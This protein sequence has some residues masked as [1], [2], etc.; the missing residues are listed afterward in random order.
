[1]H[2]RPSR[3]LCTILLILTTISVSG[4]LDLSDLPAAEEEMK[5]LVADWETQ[6]NQDPTPASELQL[7]LSLQALGIIQRQEG[8]PTEALEHL[9]R[10]CA[11]IRPLSPESLPDPLEAKALVLQD[12]GHLRESEELLREIVSLRRN[13]VGKTGLATSLA[14]L[15]L[16]LLQQGRYPEV[17]QLLDGATAETPK[18]NPAFHATLLAHRARLLHTLGSYARSVDILTQA[19]SMD[20]ENPELRL[21]I[22]S[23]LGLSQLRLGK[24]E[25][26][27]SA[28]L[29]AAEEAKRLYL[30][31]PFLAV[32]YMNNLGAIALSLGDNETADL[33]FSEAI[34]T[35][36]ASLGT[37]H[38][39]LIVPLNNLGVSKQALGDY[40]SAATYLTRAATLQEK[41]LPPI[42]L[43]IA[44]TQRNLARNSLLSRSGD[45]AKLIAKATDTG[46]KLL[47]LLIREGTERERLNFISRFDLI[48]LP[49]A[50]G[51]APTIANVLIASKARLFDSLLSSET[52]VKTPVWQ[53]I[54]ASLPEGTVLVD[55]CRYTTISQTPESR[56]GAILISPTAPPKWIPLGSDE[57]L[58]AWLT[59]FHNRLHWCSQ[60]IQN[61]H[62]P[63]PTLKLRPILRALHSQFWAPIA[64]A[65]PPGTHTIAFSPDARIHYLPLPALLDENNTPLCKTYTQV[66][67]L[68]SARD[69]LTPP[70]KT[71]LSSSPWAIFSVSDFPSGKNPSGEKTPTTDPLLALL[72]GL[73]PIPGTKI[74]ANALKRIAPP[75]SEFFHGKKATEKAFSQLDSPGVIHIGCHAFFLGDAPTLSA[76][77]M[78]F[79]DQS[80]LLFSG[81]L[82]LY[83]GA[84]RQ[85]NAPL[86]SQTD[87]LLF[88]SEIAKLPLTHTRLVTLSSCDSGAGTPVSGEGLLGI[89]RS[90]SIAGAR[91]VLVALWPV[92]DSSTPDFMDR[93]YRLALASDRPA[94]ALWQAQAEFIPPAS[95][96]E[97]NFENAI[98]KYAPFILSQNSPLEI[99]PTIHTHPA[100]DPHPWLIAASSIPLLCFIASRIL[101]KKIPHPA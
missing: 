31:R 23:Q 5:K 86:F 18:T 71:S 87:D 42:H 6:F 15:A 27:Y 56:Y 77:P 4:A 26:G 38:P 52:P 13:H 17:A 62:L 97:E 51:D 22:S 14:H 30:A 24:Y 29:A 68:S 72:S 37:D 85:P 70:P 36:Q 10:A 16:N 67:T 94:Q 84:T 25:E 19:R 100:T 48:S 43:R 90:F 7:A 2:T 95:G 59:R 3:L 99:G 78:D 33:V 35:I 46:L 49:C 21:A 47:E 96:N 76:L 101:Q 1:M 83:H 58:A 98:L 45:S 9:E 91:E 39:S 89:R 28:T 57:T 20:F 53:D 65:F 73:Q 64:A 54:S 74:E 92:S 69:L 12:L 79:D 93:F 88:P 40:L 34:G 41:H 50:T 81:G 66:T 32:P 8:K 82:I 75:E 11:I 60:K 44:E 63:P 80:S 61:P 55:I